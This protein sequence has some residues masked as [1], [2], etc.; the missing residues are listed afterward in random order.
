[1][2]SVADEIPNETHLSTKILNV[3]DEIKCTMYTNKSI[4]LLATFLS[5][6]VRHS[7]SG[8]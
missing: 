6:S 1:M 2:G 5:L 3:G 8:C 7:S 4:T